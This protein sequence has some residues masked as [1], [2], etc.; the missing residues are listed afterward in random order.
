MINKIPQ[1]IFGCRSASTKRSCTTLFLSDSYTKQN[2]YSG[3]IDIGISHLM[4]ILTIGYLLKLFSILLGDP[5]FPFNCSPG[6]QVVLHKATAIDAKAITSTPRELK[7]AFPQMQ[8]TSHPKGAG[9]CIFPLESLKKKPNEKCLVAHTNPTAVSTSYWY[10]C[11]SCCFEEVCSDAD[12]AHWSSN[13]TQS[14][15]KNDKCMLLDTTTHAK[16]QFPWLQLL[17]AFRSPAPGSW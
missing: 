12:C 15:H 5:K 10:Q 3:G 8:G 14:C 6:C 11:A 2:P 1:A 16:L 9:T 17:K 13:G 7:T 4:T